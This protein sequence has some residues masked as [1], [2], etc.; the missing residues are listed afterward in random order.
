VADLGHQDR[1]AQ[2]TSLQ[3]TR[4]RTA[5]L[6]DLGFFERARNLLPTWL[7]NKPLRCIERLRPRVGDEEDARNALLRADR[8]T[9]DRAGAHFIDPR[10]HSGTSA[11]SAA[12]VDQNTSDPLDNVLEDV[13]RALGVERGERTSSRATSSRAVRRIDHRSR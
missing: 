10:A 11:T 1:G 8:D 13:S 5:D 6:L 9:G 4:D 2:Q 12:A 7:R 3:F